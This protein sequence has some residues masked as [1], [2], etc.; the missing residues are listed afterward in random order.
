MDN[1]AIFYVYIYEGNIRALV[2]Y[3]TS[4][5]MCDIIR[6]ETDRRNSGYVYRYMMN[7][8]YDHAM[9]KKCTRIRFI[10]PSQLS[11]KIKTF[12]TRDFIYDRKVPPWW[13]YAPIRCYE[14]KILKKLGNYL[15]ILEIYVYRTSKVISAKNR[16]HRKKLKQINIDRNSKKGSIWD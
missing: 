3:R 10:C 7:I 4:T 11:R 9:D 2:A 1:G 8:I 16:L 15:T 6:F 13:P 5:K 12:S 14:N